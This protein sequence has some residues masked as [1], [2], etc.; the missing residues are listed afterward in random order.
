LLLE[1]LDQTNRITAACSLA[2]LCKQREVAYQGRF[3]NLAAGTIINTMGWVEGQGK[4]VQAHICR[5][6][7][8]DVI[9]VIGDDKLHRSMQMTF[10]VCYL[11][12]LELTSC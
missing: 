3:Q 9:L 6:F 10:H 11:L 8:A 7:R 4:E 2:D 12:V 5:A 1:Q